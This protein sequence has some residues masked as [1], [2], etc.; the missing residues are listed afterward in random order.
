MHFR[1][2]LCFP[3]I[4][5]TWLKKPTGKL[6]LK[7]SCVLFLPIVKFVKSNLTVFSMSIHMQIFLKDFF[8]PI[9]DY[10]YILLQWQLFFI[11]FCFWVSGWHILTFCFGNLGYYMVLKIIE[12][13]R[14]IVICVQCKDQRS[15]ISMMTFVSFNIVIISMQIKCERLLLSGPEILS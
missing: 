11:L 5:I 4:S 15:L 10:F 13:L 9:K 1:Y 3:N 8:L 14:D 12:F 2:P 6:L 7:V